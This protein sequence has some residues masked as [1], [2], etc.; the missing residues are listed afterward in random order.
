VHMVASLLEMHMANTCHLSKEAYLPK[1]PK[2]GKSRAEWY[3]KAAMEGDSFG[4][5]NLGSLYYNGKG[6]NRDFRKAVEWYEKAV[7]AGNTLAMRNLAICYELGQGV[8]PDVQRA[9]ELYE[10]AAMAGDAIAMYNLGL[11]YT[12]GNG[13]R[14]NQPLG[15]H[16]L[17]KSARTGKRHDRQDQHAQYRRDKGFDKCNGG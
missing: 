10:K 17:E 8:A 15:L 6:V 1:T 12:Q 9:L 16:W 13:V 4:L 2:N 5:N 7:A 14:A 11:C 3:E